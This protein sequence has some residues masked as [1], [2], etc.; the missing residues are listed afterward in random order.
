MGRG[1][2]APYYI[3]GCGARQYRTRSPA[4]RMPD[5]LPTWSLGL[6]WLPPKCCCDCPSGVGLDESD[7][8]I[9]YPIILPPP[10]RGLAE[11]LRE[12]RG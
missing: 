1:R 5:Q 10:E 2:G 6:T 12:S 11:A 8:P 4:P 9:R 7:R 3:N